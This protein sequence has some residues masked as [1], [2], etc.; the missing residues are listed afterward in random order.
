M[1][2]SAA[3]P[4]SS[5]RSTRRPVLVVATTE[6]ER[7]GGREGKREREGSRTRGCLDDK[8]SLPSFFLSLFMS[9]NE[10]AALAFAI[11]LM[12]KGQSVSS[13]RIV[14]YAARLLQGEGIGQTSAP[15][16]RM[17]EGVGGTWWKTVVFTDCWVSCTLR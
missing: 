1:S 12:H 8:A 15:S 4:R 17:T 6:R 5:S 16:S 11:A 14:L 7:E 9:S 3:L 13:M 10:R 2:E